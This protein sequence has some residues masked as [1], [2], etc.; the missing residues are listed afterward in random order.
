MQPLIFGEVLFDCFANGKRILGGAP[1]NVAWHLAAFGVQPL[2]VSCVG[3]DADG[4]TI[5]QRMQDWHM[6]Q[7]GIQRTA[8]YPT[9]TVQVTIEQNEPQYEIV[10]PA[11]WDFVAAD[12]LPAVATAPFIYHGTLALRH[13]VSRA[14]FQHLLQRTQ[15]PLFMDVNLRNP[16]WQQDAV[17]NW[18]QQ[19]AWIKLNRDE[20]KRLLPTYATDAERVQYLLALPKLRY[21]LLTKGEAGAEL[22][23][24][25]GER[26]S[27]TP[28]PGVTAFVDAV[29]AGDAF[30]S[31][32][33]LGTLLQWHASV[34]LQ[35][36]Q[37][38]ASA[39]VGIRGATTSDPQFYQPFRA[40]WGV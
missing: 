30:T 35:R 22:H 19:A 40:E 33:L 4:D 13:D 39:V 15:A 12:A 26:W 21:L 8:D 29:G 34:T 28:T 18:M 27:V 38:F 17:L 24:V 23:A 16:W 3:N 32:F 14:A 10:K 37:D 2:M 11:A 7:A 5:R 6:N 9:G 25:S 20:L 1:F 31:I 36:A